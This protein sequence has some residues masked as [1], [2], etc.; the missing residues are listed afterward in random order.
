MTVEARTEAA[1]P[2]PLATD[3]VTLEVIRSHLITTCREMG[4]AMMRT[5]YSPIFNEGLDFSCVIFD[6]SGEMIAQADFCPAMIG[7]IVH[8]VEWAIKEVGP[9]NMEPGDVILHNDPYRNGCHLPEFMVLKPCFVDG[10]IVA[11]TANIAH[12]VDIGGMVPAAFGD[13]RNIFQEGL[14]LPP[15]KIYRRDEEVEDLFKVLIS[16]VRTPTYAYGDLKAMIGSLYL[17]E[18]RIREVVERY[19]AAAFRQCGEDIKTVSERLARAAIAALPDGEYTFE[20]A[21]EDDGVDPDEEW[22][23]KVAMVVR[24]DEVIADYTGSSPQSGGPANQTWGV[25]ASATYA[26]MFNIFGTIPFNHGCYRPISVIA[27]PGTFV[28]VEYPGSCVGGNSDSSPTSVDVVLGALSEVAG[29]GT[30]SDGDTHGIL[31]LGG[32]DPRSGQAF[33]HLYFDGFGWGGRY[34]HDGN[35]AQVGKTSNC[36]NTPV[37]VLETRYPLECVEYSLNTDPAGRPGAGRHRGGF[38]T[39]RVLRVTAPE[40][41]VSAHTNRNRLRP[42]GA[43][44]GA[45]GGNCR[46]RFR[47]AGEDGWGTAVELFGRTSPGKFSNLDLAAGD[48]IEVSLPGGGGYGDP[49]TRDPELVAADVRHGYYTVAE[50]DSLYGVVLA[51]DGS[52][53]AAAT[54]RRRGVEP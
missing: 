48:E 6:G 40:M 51:A 4:I 30:A 37:E 36:A 10:E 7:A 46:V 16:N 3:P 17:A 49:L 32:V 38:G 45:D 53:D 31:S 39:R 26:A 22:K 33:A 44:G 47:R 25:T 15:V 54:A 50:A 29:K 24:G 20:G 52:V 27:P 19:G 35:D 11:Y 34:S 43:D 9:E 28:N 13:T 41:I 1:A 23:I 12:M 8:V 42:W 21:I 5:S 18:R 14:R 2:A